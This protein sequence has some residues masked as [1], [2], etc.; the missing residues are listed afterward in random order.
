MGQHP[1]T[2]RARL[3]H[4]Q[5]SRS[6]FRSAC[7]LK[8]GPLDWFCCL[9]LV[10]RYFRNTDTSRVSSGTHLASVP[11]AA[12]STHNSFYYS[13]PVVSEDWMAKRALAVHYSSESPGWLGSP[14]GRMHCLIES[15]HNFDILT[16]PNNNAKHSNELNWT[17]VERGARVLTTER[18]DQPECASSGHCCSRCQASRSS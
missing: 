3:G 8:A 16:G 11:A 2:T 6:S 14:F 17:R 4:I 1:T 18:C 15:A 13:H 9:L 5:I 10:A 7:A 12:A